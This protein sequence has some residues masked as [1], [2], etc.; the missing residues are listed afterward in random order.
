MAIKTAEIHDVNGQYAGYAKFDRTT[1]EFRGTA[2][3]YGSRTNPNNGNRGRGQRDMGETPFNGGLRMQGNRNN[4][5]LVQNT[6]RTAG[7]RMASRNPAE[8]RRR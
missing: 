7:S 2:G 1:G 6:A 3:G 8:K 4:A 5:S